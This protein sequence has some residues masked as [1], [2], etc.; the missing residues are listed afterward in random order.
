M[1]DVKN[2]PGEQV[3]P[4]QVPMIAGRV[5]GRVDQHVRDVLRI[6]DLL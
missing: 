1:D 6:L 2:Y 5:A 3:V 4:R